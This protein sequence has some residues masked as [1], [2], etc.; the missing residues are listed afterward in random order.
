[1][2]H[3]VWLRPTRSV[4]PQDISMSVTG[5]AAILVRQP[6]GWLGGFPLPAYVN[7][8]AGITVSRKASISIYATTIP[9][10]RKRTVSFSP[11]TPLPCGR[12]SRSHHQPEAWSQLVQRG[13]RAN[14]GSHL[15]RFRPPYR[16]PMARNGSLPVRLLSR[17]LSARHFLVTFINDLRK[18]PIRFFATVA[19]AG[20]R[21]DQ[22]DQGPSRLRPLRREAAW[23][24]DGDMPD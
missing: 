13:F 20:I 15:T 2:R 21:D 16:D 9:I 11:A 10:C 18:D 19:G 6:V 12:P 1:M 14:S 3:S 22:M 17:S 23:G 7:W 24:H 8:N 5:G 4:L